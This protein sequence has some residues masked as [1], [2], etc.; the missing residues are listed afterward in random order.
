LTVPSIVSSKDVRGQSDSK[1][2]GRGIRGPAGRIRAT[3]VVRKK[4][5]RATN[6]RFVDA[7]GEFL[8]VVN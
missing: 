8:P 3:F 7:G 1:E 4:S 5:G 2:E 6:V